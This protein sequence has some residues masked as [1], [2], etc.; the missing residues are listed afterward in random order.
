MENKYLSI[1]ALQKAY[2]ILEK[3]E[4]KSIM[5]F[6]FCQIQAYRASKYLID[7]GIEKSIVDHSADI[8]NISLAIILMNRNKVKKIL[9]MIDNKAFW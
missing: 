8:F 2:K 1:D 6:G 9:F 4:N 5:E 3:G 7:I